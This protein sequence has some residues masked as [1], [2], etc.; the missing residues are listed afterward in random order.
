MVPEVTGGAF[1]PKMFTRSTCA[2][3]V[4]EMSSGETVKFHGSVVVAPPGSSPAADVKGFAARLSFELARA[5]ARG[6]F[7]ATENS[8]DHPAAEA[9]SKAAV[10]AIL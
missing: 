5:S 4:Q 8:P 3:V 10:F 1:V 9:V 6:P 2:F 7:S